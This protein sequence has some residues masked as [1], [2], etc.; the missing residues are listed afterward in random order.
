[1]LILDLPI[2]RLGTP[3]PFE[4]LT[5]TPSG[6]KI[7]LSGGSVSVADSGLYQVS[8]G[9]DE[10]NVPA[11]GVSVSLSIDGV[12]IL[13]SQNAREATHP[14]TSFMTTLIINLDTITI[15]HILQLANTTVAGTVSFSG[16]GGGAP[17]AAGPTVFMTILKL[18]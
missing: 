15:P 8:F 3:I 6:S 7:S 5:N 2:E 9:F 12:F 1:M 13:G 18:Q 17:P 10:T 4:F 11:T 16:T 14:N